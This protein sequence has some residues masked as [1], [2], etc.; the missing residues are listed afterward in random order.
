MLMD[1][2]TTARLLFAEALDGTQILPA[3]ARKVH[4]AGPIL[5]VDTT[6]L[7]LCRFPDLRIVGLG[8]AAVPM[9]QALLDVLD[10]ELS[11]DHNLRGLVIGTG[12]PAIPDDRITYRLGAHPFP[13]KTSA[14]A[15]QAV[16]D[17]LAGASNDTLVLFL[18]SGGAS[19]MADLPLDPTIPLADLLTFHQ[20]LVHSGLPIAEMNT[21]RKHVSAIKGGRLAAAAHPATQ[22]TLL[23]S[24]V[25]AARPDIIASGPTLPDPTTLPDCRR[26]LATALAHSPIPASIRGFLLDPQT[27]ETPKADHPAFTR[28]SVHTLLSSDDLVRAAEAAATAQGFR[29]E[30]DLTPDDWPFDEA[31]SYLLK[32]LHVLTQGHP[33]QPVCLLSAGELA[34]PVTSA[35]PGTGG[36]NAHFA[37]HCAL[38]LAGLRTPTAILSAG[39]DG[40]DGNSPA[41]GGVVDHTTTA[42]AAK[43]NLD[44][45]RALATFDS[46]TLLHALGDTVITGP[47]GNNLRDLRVLLAAP[48]S[49]R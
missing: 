47:T 41:A 6:T 21:L 49:R 19:A 24:D 25:P 27:P 29:T 11:S 3:F 35:V 22:C 12:A 10:P 46:Y 28:A 48:A 14:N 23:V 15:A 4:C 32:R 5:Q 30:I 17:F 7:D 43:Q 37:L 18:I 44:P 42:R 13:D 26:L 40:I 16:L 20:A 2:R 39:S 38:S 8:K 45:A 34:V 31:A 33:D 36:R 9:A 1:L